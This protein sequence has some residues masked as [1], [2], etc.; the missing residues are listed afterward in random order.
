MLVKIH[1]IHWDKRFTKRKE[2]LDFTI[3][4]TDC[5]VTAV[6]HPCVKW[7]IGEAW[8][9]VSSWLTKKHA[10]VTLGEEKEICEHCNNTNYNK[11]GDLCICIRHWDR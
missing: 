11:N 8:Y 2:D 9:R 6:S 4:D 5:F 1:K 10:L 3:T 7:A